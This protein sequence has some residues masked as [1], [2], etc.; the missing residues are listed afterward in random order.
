MQEWIVVLL[1]TTANGTMQG[2]FS[3]PMK[4]VEECALRAKQDATALMRAHPSAKGY[5]VEAPEKPAAPEAF[6]SKGKDR[7]A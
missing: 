3:E 4:S 7:D 6:P 5:C 1:V 2:G